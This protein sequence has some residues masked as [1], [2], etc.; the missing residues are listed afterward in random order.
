M[1]SGKLLLLSYVPNQV[2]WDMYLRNKDV[3]SPRSR[4]CLWKISNANTSYPLKMLNLFQFPIFKYKL[5]KQN[6]PVKALSEVGYK[7]WFLV[8]LTFLLLYQ[9][10]K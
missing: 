7:S 6:F 8:S 4:D 2:R 5:M 1:Y 3:L 9:E 10:Q